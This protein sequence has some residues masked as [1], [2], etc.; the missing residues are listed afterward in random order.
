MTIKRTEQDIIIVDPLHR[1]VASQNDISF[2]T[3]ENL[4][5]TLSLLLASRASVS[6]PPT[7]LMFGSNET[8]L[9][10][11]VNKW[12]LPLM[13]RMDYKSFPEN[14][15]MGGI[16]LNSYDTINK[17]CTFLF[18][19]NCYPILQI[20]LDRFADEYSVG[21]L[22]EPGKSEYTVEVVGVGFDASDLRLGYTEFHESFKMN[23]FE[24]E[25]LEPWTVISKSDYEKGRQSRIQKVIWLKKYIKYAN[26]KGI[27]LP[28]LEI[29][30]EIYS[31]EEKYEVSIPEE[32][33]ILPISY[34]KDLNKIITILCTKVIKK[35]PPSKKFVASLSYTQ[36]RGW[37][38]WDVYGQWYNRTPIQRD[39]TTIRVE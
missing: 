29:P 6:I 22:F 15:T 18:K 36:K 39:F 21:V 30:D 34:L 10:D 31:D 20:Y 23:V 26:K 32:Y 4:L 12:K 5:K 8:A 13:I 19:E 11:I 27:L 7:V 1:W 3:R 17:V 25:K 37:V 14:K 33:Q 16:P 2:L 24:D 9:K 35:L 38:L 28:S